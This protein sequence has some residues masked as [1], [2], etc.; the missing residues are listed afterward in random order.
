MISLEAYRAAIGIFYLTHL[1]HGGKKLTSVVEPFNNPT[2]LGRI[3]NVK[4]IV[5]LMLFFII[6]C[7]F[8][9]RSLRAREILNLDQ[10]S[11]LT[12]CSLEHVLTCII[13]INNMSFLNRMLLLRSGDVESNPGPTFNISKVVQASFHQG[14]PKFGDSAGIQCASC[15]L[16]F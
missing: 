2:F 9:L 11:M 4:L 10:L 1:S 8:F 5:K 6:L 16:V 3:F 14:H 7:M 15:S 13:V 12:W